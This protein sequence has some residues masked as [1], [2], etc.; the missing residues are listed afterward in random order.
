MKASGFQKISYV[1]LFIILS[2]FLL[3]IIPTTASAASNWYDSA[4]SNRKMI[5]V[6]GSQISGTVNNF[7]VLVSFTDIDL[8]IAQTLGQDI[9]ITDS[10]TTP[11]KLDHEIEYYNDSTGELILW[12]N[13]P[14]LTNANNTELYI[15]Y[16]NGVAGDQQSVAAT[17]DSSFSMVQHLEETS[18]IEIDSTSN[19]NDGTQSGTITRNASGKIGL[20]D[21][22]DGSTG[23]L[24]FGN[25]GVTGNWTVEFWANMDALPASIFYPV[26]LMAGNNGGFLAWSGSP[27]P[28]Q[29]GVYEGTTPPAAGGYYLGSV[30]SA[31]S[32]NHYVVTN[33]GTTYSLY[34]NGNLKIQGRWFKWILAC[35][36]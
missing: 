11:S 23:Y 28:Y 15:Y 35:L 24:S 34:K 21:D 29:W 3:L 31:S 14:S 2:S 30:V 27:S 19:G 1:V 10:A 17:W 12:V 4:W 8:T 20:A 7:P 9:L 36:R 22:F 32:W 26:S 16:G 25:T 6:Q 18:S 13:V 33:S 5:T